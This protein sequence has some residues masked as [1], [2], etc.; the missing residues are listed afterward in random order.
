[1]AGRQIYNPA[2]FKNIE[3]NGKVKGYQY[4]FKAQY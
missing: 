3:E 2:G 4:Q 1:M